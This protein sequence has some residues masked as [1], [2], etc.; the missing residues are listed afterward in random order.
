MANEQKSRGGHMCLGGC[1]KELKSK[2]RVCSACR[3]RNS[4]YGVVVT[5]AKVPG[6]EIWNPK[7]NLNEES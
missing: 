7:S 1:G 3:K 4:R 6:R 2:V 5:R